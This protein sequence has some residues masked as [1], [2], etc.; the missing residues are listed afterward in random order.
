[1]P[2]LTCRHCGTPV[3]LDEPLPRDL[4]C[5]TCGRDLRAC[6]HCRHYD[7]RYNNACRETMADPVVEKDRRNF[8]EYFS[9]SREP[10]VGKAPA[11]D[12][13]ADARAKLEGLFGGGGKR[14]PTRE[15]EARRKLEDLFKKKS[16]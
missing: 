10:F 5:E 1:M 8:C 6:V 15:D 3:P 11:R 4:A 16:E 14:G 13:A 9:F 7:E 12:R 2:S